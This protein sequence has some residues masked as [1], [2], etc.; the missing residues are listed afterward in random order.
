MANTI[1]QTNLAADASTVDNILNVVSATGISAPTG[2]FAQKLYII[3]PDSCHGE[4]VDVTAVN[5][6]FVQVSRLD[7]FKQPL[8]GP[9][10]NGGVGATVLI[11]PSAQQ[12]ALYNGPLTTGFQEFNPVGGSTAPQ[13]SGALQPWLNVDSGE[14]WLYSSLL[15]VWVPGWNNPK[16]VKGLTAAVASVAGFLTPS[17][18]LFHV[19]GALAVTGITAPIGFSGGSFTVIADG[20]FTWTAANNIGATGTGVV[21]KTVTFTYDSN[22]GKWYASI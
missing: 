19:T 15:R 8:R 20:A 13:S 22:V 18:P 7:K 2:G 4:L 14:Q 6:T 11:A 10:G 12:S 9:S 5:G 1:T 17:G 16:G 21:G 3:N